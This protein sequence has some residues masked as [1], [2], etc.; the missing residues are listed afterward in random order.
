MFRIRDMDE[1]K[2]VLLLLESLD[3]STV[4]FPVD[5]YRDA[6]QVS[7]VQRGA[8]HRCAYVYTDAEGR[9]VLEGTV[10]NIDLVH[11][12]QAMEKE[13]EEEAVAGC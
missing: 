13:F 11:T 1:L 7:A 12:L 6:I 10:Y 3:N 9:A 4:K 2:R 8:S 5:I